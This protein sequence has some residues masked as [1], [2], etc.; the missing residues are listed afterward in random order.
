MDRQRFLTCPP[1][2]S[3]C[4]KVNPFQ[5]IPK[6]T[7]SQR[8][9][10]DFTEDEIRSQ[11]G[12]D[13]LPKDAASQEPVNEEAFELLHNSSMHSDKSLQPELNPKVPSK[14]MENYSEP[15]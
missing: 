11:A 15:V 7:Y 2:K 4:D 9:F 6:Y 8:T 10:K 12:K 3:P 13:V 1:D 5:E 14:S